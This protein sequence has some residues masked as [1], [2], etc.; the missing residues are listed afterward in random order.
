LFRDLSSGIFTLF[1]AT[2][3]GCLRFRSG[4]QSKSLAWL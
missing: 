2:V 4:G 1:P 3:H